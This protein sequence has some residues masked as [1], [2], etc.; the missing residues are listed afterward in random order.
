M[1][2]LLELLDEAGQSLTSGGLAPSHHLE[3]VQAPLPQLDIR[4]E[5]LVDL[6]VERKLFLGLVRPTPEVP[7]KAHKDQ[8]FPHIDRLLCHSAIH[9]LG[10]WKSYR[11]ISV[12]HSSHIRFS[13]IL[14]WRHYKPC[15][16]AFK[17]GKTMSTQKTATGSPTGY[18]NCEESS[19]G[20]Q[21]MFNVFAAHPKKPKSIQGWSIASGIFGFLLSWLALSQIMQDAYETHTF[22]AF[23]YA[24]LMG[25]SLYFLGTRI[26]RDNRKD[27]IDTRFLV[28]DQRISK[29]DESQVMKVPDITHLDVLNARTGERFSITTPV[30]QH[31][32]VLASGVMSGVIAESL[33]GTQAMPGAV[34]MTVGGVSSAATV[35]ANTIG[36]MQA[37]L[38]AGVHN[39][40]QKYKAILVE[41]S[42]QLAAVDKQGRR[43]V[44]AGGLSRNIATDL[45]RAVHR[46][47]EL[48]IVGREKER[49]EHRLY[50]S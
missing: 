14:E 24:A 9:P 16:V 46:T 30:P 47:L 32:S 12:T 48:A 25:Y 17:Q 5:R 20:T 22:K 13:H 39:A 41:H 6:Q 19:G 37:S 2:P 50:N 36:T 27:A 38:S 29:G 15:E 45:M 44:L 23:C 7:E 40:H 28:N 11:H 34:G 35:A 31:S 3:D 1:E 33:F 8:V 42:Y 4:H 21:F 43:L 26:A 10:G 49:V 18:F